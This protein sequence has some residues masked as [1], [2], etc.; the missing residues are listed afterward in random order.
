[1]EESFGAG[2]GSFGG[3]RQPESDRGGKKRRQ[4]DAAPQSA[5]GSRTSKLK[6]G[7]GSGLAF[8]NDDGE[9]EEKQRREEHSKQIDRQKNQLLKDM[10]ES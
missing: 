9:Q 4:R 7:A 3:G 1:M 2:P 8:D 6:S 10:K 5:K